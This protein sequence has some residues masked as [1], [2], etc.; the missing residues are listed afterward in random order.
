MSDLGSLSIV[1][2]MEI[3][4]KHIDNFVMETEEGT[5][6]TKEKFH[7]EACEQRNSYI[8]KQEEYYNTC[9]NEVKSEISRRLTGLMP[10]DKTAQYA[11]AQLKVDR[12]LDLVMLNSNI[13]NRFRLKFD[14]IVSSITDETSLGELNHI[15]DLFVSHMRECGISLTNEDFNYTMFTE[16]YMKSFLKHAES[17]E[18]KE[19]FERIYFA[20]PD[21]KLQLKMNLNYILMMHEKELELYAISLKTKEFQ[22]Y[23]VDSES[24]ISKYVSARQEVGTAMA[25]DE[26]Y[27]T[28]LFLEGKKKLSDYMPESPTRNKNFDMFVIGGRTHAS[29]EVG[30]QDHHDSAIMGLYLTLNEL[31]KYYH[32]EPMIKDLLER[33]KQKDSAKT[34]YLAKKKEIEKE[35]KVR[36]SIIK[37]YIKATGVSIVPAL[38]FLA[39]KSD[40]KMQEAKKRI[41]EQ[42]RKLK[43][44]YTQLDEEEISYQ[45]SEVSESASIYDLFLTALKSFP[46]LENYFKSDEYFAEKTLEQNVVEFFRFLYNPNNNFLRKINAF[47]EYDVTSVVAEKYRLLNLNVSSEIINAET[48]DSTLESVKFINLIQNVNRSTINFHQI[49]NICK[50]HEIVKVEEEEKTEEEEKFEDV[51]VD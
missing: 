24:V 11:E 4:K 23:A 16:E 7:R 30:E 25:K 37:D 48:I 50:M 27:N 51:P 42:V 49:E 17:V 22:E 15:L 1:K 43:D 39:R 38:A 14:F 3:D 35:E 21:I 41:N 44:L 9:L 47:A 26:Y 34:N 31:K 10:I 45:L 12:L 29:L 20:C 19:T 5:K 8:H 13:A 40:V 33:Y 46:F 18:L 28:M 2:K 6:R 32:Y 36:E